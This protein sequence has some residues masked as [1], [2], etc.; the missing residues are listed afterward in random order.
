[1]TP[2]QTTASAE[3]NQDKKN[4]ILFSFPDNLETKKKFDKRQRTNGKTNILNLVTA[5]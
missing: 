3:M 5:V 4:Q 1:M 2:N